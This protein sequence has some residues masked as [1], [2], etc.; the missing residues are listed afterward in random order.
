MPALNTFRAGGQHPMQ[1]IRVRRVFNNIVRDGKALS[2]RGLS[3]KNLFSMFALTWSRA[4]CAG[5]AFR[6]L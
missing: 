2:A 3:G 5:F 4:W 6:S 1:C